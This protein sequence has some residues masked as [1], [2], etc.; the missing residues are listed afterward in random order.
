ML[1][2]ILELKSIVPDFIIADKIHD[3]FDTLETDIR[4]EL[5][6]LLYGG[7]CVDA[8]RQ[9]HPGI[10]ISVSNVYGRLSEIRCVS[11]AENCYISFI[12]HDCLIHQGARVD[13]NLQEEDSYAAVLILNIT[14]FSSIPDEYSMISSAVSAPLDTVLRG[15]EPTLFPIT[16]TT[17]LFKTQEPGG[18]D[19]TGYHVAL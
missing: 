18:S 5:G 19:D 6:V 4:F 17:S 12:C 2:N 8:N 14:S 7:E 15:P 3:D 13:L 1:D 11:D 16:F 9:C 10:S